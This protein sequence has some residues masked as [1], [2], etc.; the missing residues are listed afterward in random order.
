MKTADY[1]MTSDRIGVIGKGR[2]ERP[3]HL[4]DRTRDALDAYV[5]ARRKHAHAAEEW[6]WLGGKGRLTDSGIAQAM[7]PRAAGR[8]R[9][10]ASP[11]L[12]PRLAPSCR[13]RQGRHAHP[14]GRGRRSS[15]AMLRRYASTTRNDRA[16]E[17]MRKIGLGD[18]L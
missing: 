15:D 8:H 1:S 12:P 16:I 11:R 10:A 18:K 14:H 7:R 9:G 4:A 17:A 13:G 5:R 3:V 6:F 2:K